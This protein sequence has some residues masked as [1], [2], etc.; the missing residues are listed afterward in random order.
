M[1]LR[2]RIRILEETGENQNI[3]EMK[4][5]Q[6]RQSFEA[7]SKRNNFGTAI[8]GE[9]IGNP[10]TFLNIE[11]KADYSAAGQDL[12]S[13][14]E[15][16]MPSLPDT[17]G[18]VTLRETYKK[19]PK[20][21]KNPDLIDVMPKNSIIAYNITGQSSNIN[22]Q[23]EVFFP[24]FP[25]HFSMPVKPG[26]QVW[27]FYEHIGTGAGSRKIGYWLFRKPGTIHTDDLN[28]THNDRQI[29][30]SSIINNTKFDG[31]SLTQKMEVLTSRLYRYLDFK[32]GGEGTG[33]FPVHPDQ[34]VMDSI[35][36]NT[37]FVGEAVP[38]YTKKSGD[39]VLQGS[40]NTAIIM[41]HANEPNTGWIGMI[42]GRGVHGTE[43][44]RQ[45]SKIKATRTLNEAKKYEHFEIDK[46]A[47][48]IK[49]DLSNL[50]SY[51]EAVKQ[52]HEGQHIGKG[53]DPASVFV[54]TNR[55]NGEVHM[56]S[57]Y[58]VMQDVDTNPALAAPYMTRASSPPETGGVLGYSYMKLKDGNMF[59][60]GSSPIYLQ[61][62]SQ[63]YI[64]YDEFE[65]LMKDV[66]D[67]INKVATDV[68]ALR[69]EWFVFLST[70]MA[71]MTSLGSAVGIG[72]A[73]AGAAGVAQGMIVPVNYYSNPAHPKS[74]HR[75]TAKNGKRVSEIPSVKSERLFG[76]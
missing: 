52:D 31:L 39:F 43:V 20:A 26:E 5:D 16:K 55:G 24:F 34:I 13:K 40:N 42:A 29:I 48:L 28:Y 58:G 66:I 54:F 36:Y 30:A 72:A 11:D 32:K 47:D 18:K 53:Y 35:S 76:E 38:R 15:G 9:F 60:Y 27:T 75:D 65:A 25:Q 46:S 37:E 59:A 8:V 41:S 10:V 14:F 49:G 44:G 45:I 68:D 3:T 21:V 69:G 56:Q 2:R 7:E 4:F 71:D 74:V 19:G 33:T 70:L 73:T 23:A 50:G 63:P 62:A 1:S 67:D 12:R 51:A 6:I 22:K 61:E 57:N 17:A 64:R